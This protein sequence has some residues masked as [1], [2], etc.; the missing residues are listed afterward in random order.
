MSTEDSIKFVERLYPEGPWAL[1]AVAV[2]KKGIET[3]TFYPASVAE[4]RSWIE[5]HNGVRNLYFHI[6]PVRYAMSKKAE[7]TDIE[8][9][10]FFHVDLDAE[11]G[12]DLDSERTRLLLSLTSNRPKKVPEPSI[13]VSSGGGIQAFWKLQEPI[14]IQGELSLAENA[15]RYNQQLELIFSADN[16]HNIDRIMRLP[17]TMNI[18][19]AK[20]LKKGRVKEEARVLQFKDLAYA[21]SE[22]IQAPLIILQEKDVS[23]N[24]ETIYDNCKANISGNIRRLVSIDELDE[25]NV[26]DRVKV[27]CVQGRHPEQNK[28]G[29]DS[30]SAWLF[31]GVC[32]LV[33]HNVPDD[34]IYS[35]ITDPDF[36]ISESVLEW[37][38][39]AHSYAIRQI[40]KAKEQAIDADLVKLNQRYV[41]ISNYGG[42]CRII[43][44]VQ[45]I[46]LGR[47]RITKQS[48]EDFRN[49]WMNRPKQVGVDDKGVPKFAPM[50]HWWLQHPQRNQSRTLVFVPNQKVDPKEAYNLWQGFAVDGKPG[51]CS[52]LLDHIEHNVCASNA[53]HFDYLMN[54]MARAVQQPASPGETAIVMR[55]SMGVGKSFLAQVFG[56]LWGPHYMMVSN[57]AHIVGNFNGHLQDVC[58]LFADEAFFAGDK[59]HRSVLRALITDP[60][61]PVE[62]KGVDV[63]IRPN[64]LHIWMAS[65]DEWVIP[66]GEDERRYLILDV[67]KRKHQDSAYFG[68]I[69]KQL[70]SKDEKG[71]PSNAGYSAFLHVLLSRDISN[72]DV[73]SVPKTTA[74]QQQKD[75][76]L[77][78]EAE[79][80]QNKLIEGRILKTQDSWERAI[81][82]DYL[83]D[84][85]VSYVK[86]FNATA[87]GSE[88]RL[89]HMLKSFVPTLGTSQ[90]TVS[91]KE[92]VGDGISI[93]GPPRRVYHYEF[94]SLADCRTAW[95]ERFGK[96]VWDAE[97]QA[98]LGVYANGE[99]LPF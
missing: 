83:V 54:W 67:S 20:K 60:Q 93:D 38:G 88:T 80:W 84:D 52:L 32:Q 69:R 10:N 78:T 97:P 40:E 64:Y 15:K 34:V 65:N 91:L 75:F 24:G 31:D 2:D 14:A 94:P 81:P 85:F 86:R 45:D 76:S 62:S 18:P 36:G 5:S 73:R 59:R 89:G 9:V 8:S 44:R 50:G 68:E 95:D 61:M 29:D 6:N 25:W 49:V 42:R 21:L 79:W 51:D 96:R 53:V 11:A 43:E 1:T 87:R 7:R 4:M 47:S 70:E 77:G 19:D 23:F 82:K 58:F 63:E 39:R 98:S 46:A 56:Y 72:F 92:W 41:V 22:F 71:K 27:V 13:I 3:R 17:G 37:K 55:G 28:E 48:F 90:K 35:I 16:C 33:R 26:P 66:A 12:A 30:R 74:L 57:S 99:H